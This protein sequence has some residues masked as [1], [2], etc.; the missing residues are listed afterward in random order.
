MTQISFLTTTAHQN[1]QT[2]Q[3]WYGAWRQPRCHQAVLTIPRT[4]K[5]SLHL[6]TLTHSEQL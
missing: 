5:F 1:S 4:P 2:P 6:R 3:L